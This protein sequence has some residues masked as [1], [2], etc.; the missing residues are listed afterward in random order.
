MLTKLK[1]GQGSLGERPLDESKD[2][3][4]QPSQLNP[5]AQVSPA[6]PAQGG[7]ERVD[8]TLRKRL[9]DPA[10]SHAGRGKGI[11]SLIALTQARASC[12]G[13]KLDE[14]EFQERLRLVGESGWS[15]ESQ[16]KLI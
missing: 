1:T 7:V 6:S 14:P 2:V 13:G 9:G 5:A 10:A 3:E 12:G 4:V 11:D 8:A 15:I 16:Q